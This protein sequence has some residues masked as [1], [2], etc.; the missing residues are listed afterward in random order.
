MNIGKQ[1]RKLT[2]VRNHRQERYEHWLDRL[3]KGEAKPEE[4]KDKEQA[5][6]K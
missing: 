1:I 3:I 6:E 5:S 4:N 2:L